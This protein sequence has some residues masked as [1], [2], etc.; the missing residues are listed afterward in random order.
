M[1]CYK[2]SVTPHYLF[3]FYL[4]RVRTYVCVMGMVCTTICTLIQQQALAQ[5]SNSEAR[6]LS[7]ALRNLDHLRKG[8]KTS[9]DEVEH[10]GAELLKKYPDSKAQGHIYY[11][12]AHIYA[13]SGLAR[14]QSAV[15]Y[16]KKAMQFPLEPQQKIRL[17]G[18]WGSAVYILNQKK[19]LSEKRQMATVVFLDGLTQLQKMKL[20]DISPETPIIDL[21]NSDI[22]T[23]GDAENAM[24]QN[25]DLQT[26]VDQARFLQ[27]MVRY[28]KSFISQIVWLYSR[29]PHATQE[30]QN[31]TLKITNNPELADQLVKTVD[32]KI[33]GIKEPESPPTKGHH[34]IVT[35]LSKNISTEPKSQLNTAE[36]DGKKDVQFENKKI[37]CDDQKQNSCFGQISSWTLALGGAL[38]VLFVMLMIRKYGRVAKKNKSNR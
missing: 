9:F 29:E 14:P 38:L 30:L 13:Q 12:L 8:D 4:A 28:R 3:P 26:A 7:I 18:Y 32:R 11:E 23:A 16:A 31:L 27:E 21:D 1:V 20:P 36:K 10:R 35:P 6:E 24:N 33:K 37:A 15:D 22:S 19:T 5:A 2:K 34:E 25:H 17:Y